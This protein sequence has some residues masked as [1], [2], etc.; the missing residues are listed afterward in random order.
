M[1][2][3]GKVFVITLLAALA[4]GVEPGAE[5]QAPMRI[6]ATPAQTGVYV[7]LGQNQLRTG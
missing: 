6:G 7:V 1:S 5:A 4:W 2:H 3:A